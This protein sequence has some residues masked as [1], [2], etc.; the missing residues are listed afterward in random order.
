M[1]FLQ[2]TSTRLHTRLIGYIG[3]GSLLLIFIAGQISDYASNAARD[4]ELRAIAV[5][6]AISEA[7]FEISQ[8]SV[9]TALYLDSHDLR[10]LNETQ[11][12]RARVDDHLRQVLMHQAELRRT[13]S[14][15]DIFN[16]PSD[17]E[18]KELLDYDVAFAQ[19]QEYEK[20]L[21][22]PSAPGLRDA[23]TA[24]AEPFADILLSTDPAVVRASLA[25]LREAD[26]ISTPGA[27]LDTTSLIS[28][29]DAA[30]AAVSQSSTFT[31]QQ[32]QRFLPALEKYSAIAGEFISVAQK[33]MVARAKLRALS[34]SASANFADIATRINSS[35]RGMRTQAASAQT[36]IRWL[37]LGFSAFVGFTF[38]FL[39]N[40]IGRR[41]R[42]QANT[43]LTNE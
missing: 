31:V 17:Y 15:F 35:L 8:L 43:I 34:Q 13:I 41:M 37:N 5:I 36:L 33:Q 23:F 24:A 14:Y 1:P 27:D 9:T 12:L 6:D 4:E 10:Q 7:R 29:I 42:A 28:K 19:A 22:T 11:A 16:E 21:G 40:T 25:V 38:I 3:V 20:V 2:R 32:K 18:F 39:A 26:R 30:G